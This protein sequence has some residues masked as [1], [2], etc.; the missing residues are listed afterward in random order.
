[1]KLYGAQ[2]TGRAPH[3]EKHT[4]RRPPGIAAQLVPQQT[5]EVICARKWEYVAN[6]GGFRWCAVADKFYPQV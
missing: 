6:H 2:A 5:L 1:M 4:F 3:T